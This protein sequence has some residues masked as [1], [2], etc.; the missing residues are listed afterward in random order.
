MESLHTFWLVAS[1]K[2]EGSKSMMLVIESIYCDNFHGGLL[3]LNV[4]LGGST[5]SQAS[6]KVCSNN[7]GF[8]TEVE[9]VNYSSTSTGVNLLA[10]EVSALDSSFG[11]SSE[12]PSAT[13]HR[14]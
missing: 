4:D 2:L 12:G 7:L 14:S 3:S 5:W 1:S 13:T 8:L 6:H 10:L 11:S 9:G